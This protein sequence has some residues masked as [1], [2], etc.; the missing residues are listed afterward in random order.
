MIDPYRV[1]GVQ[2]G[3]SATELKQAWLRKVRQLH[4]DTGGDP[5]KFK[6]VTAA[7]EMLSRR[8]TGQTSGWV[9]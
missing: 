9:P 6:E 2:S 5:A 1:L 7:Y 3:V 4:P 8:G